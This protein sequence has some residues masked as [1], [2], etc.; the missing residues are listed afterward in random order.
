MEYAVV[1]GSGTI[2]AKGFP[3]PRAASQ[4]IGQMYDEGFNGT[5]SVVSAEEMAEMEGQI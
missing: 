5:L 4:Y 3:T 1:D 2:Q